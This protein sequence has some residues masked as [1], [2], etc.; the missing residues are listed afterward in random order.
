MSDALEIE[1]H[2]PIKEQVL[3]SLPNIEQ[4]AEEMYAV[5]QTNYIEYPNGDHSDYG[6][7]MGELFEK[8]ISIENRLVDIRTGT[9]RVQ[10]LTESEQLVNSKF[11]NFVKNRNRFGFEK[12]H[13]RNADLAIFETYQDNPNNIYVL[14]DAEAKAA[15]FLDRRNLSQFKNFWKSTNKAAYFLNNNLDTTNHGLSEFGKSRI[16]IQVKSEQN[17]KHYLIVPKESGWNINNIDKHFKKNSEDTR[18]G[19]TQS[20]I[21]EFKGMFEKGEIQIR[22]SNV[23]RSDLKNLMEKIMPRVEKLIEKNLHEA[24]HTSR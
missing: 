20:E 22:E 14:G 13:D 1:N 19:L 16:K 17:Y 23:S 2:L 7:I 15:T 9:K 4:L 21:I 12:T 24:E 5:L 6:I 10:P 3:N 18:S 8:L 11:M